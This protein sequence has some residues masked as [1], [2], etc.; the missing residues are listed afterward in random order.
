MFA[1]MEDETSQPGTSKEETPED[2][3]R[4]YLNRFQAIRAAIGAKGDLASE[5]NTDDLIAVSVKLKTMSLTYENI[6]SL[7]KEFENT[8]VEDIQNLI[9]TLEDVVIEAETS[10]FQHANF[11]T[12]PE[13]VLRLRLSDDEFEAAKR[14]SEIA[15]N[16][17]TKKKVCVLTSE[18]L[19]DA[20]TI[21]SNDESG[22]KKVST[23]F[24]GSPPVFTDIY[25]L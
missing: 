6:V 9:Q 15:T 14:L 25:R 22:K 1:D 19:K 21:L 18:R 16:Q 3:R 8:T 20:L 24:R 10:R 11:V 23:G 7:A 5:W 2:P 13:A 17:S 12:N 4:A